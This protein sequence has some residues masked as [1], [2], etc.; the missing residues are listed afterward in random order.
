MEVEDISVFP[1]LFW[2]TCPYLKRVVGQL[3]SKAA[4]NELQQ[5]IAED[6]EFA[7]EVEK[8]ISHPCRVEKRLDSRRCSKASWQR[9]T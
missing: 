4:I 5:R 6:P 8:I 1:T 9:I 2:L 7:S 3:E